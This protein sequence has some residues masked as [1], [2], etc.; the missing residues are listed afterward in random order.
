MTADDTTFFAGAPAQQVAALVAALERRRFPEGAVV[1]AEGDAPHEMY[2]IESGVVEIWTGG[3]RDGRLLARLGPGSTVGEMSLFTGQPVSATARVAAG[4]PVDALVVGQDDFDRL[5]TTFPR[6]Y[7]NLGAIMAER[8]AQT[9]RLRAE[10]ERIEQEL[11]TAQ[12]IQ[13]T[14]LPKEVPTPVG[15]EIVPYYQPAHE[16]GGDFYDFLQ[17]ADGRL[18]LVIGD[19]TGKGIPAALVM[20]ATHTMIRAAAQESAS[21]GQ[22]FARV[23]DL[24]HADIPPGTFVT[25]FYAV[26]E[27]ESGRLRF[28]NAGHEAP[29]RC[30]AGHATELWASGM[31]LGLMPGTQYEEYDAILAPGESL[32]FYSDG[33][34]E[35]H[36]SSHEMFGLARVKTLLEADADG[37]DADGAGAGT[38][39]G[40]TLIGSLLDALRR[41][42]GEGGEQ[43]D[44][45]TLVVLHRAS[46]P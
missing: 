15:W 40:T 45:V 18:G 30:L 14:F 39:S 5:A 17:L 27:P 9:N 43:E 28:A 33:L 42:T 34:V 4:S 46:Q 38:F 13:H 11:Q 36:S 1:L 2:I 41:F 22:I 16:L 24:L 29:F 23:N 8:L 31:P 20:T 6:L 10:P 35:A 21:P 3:S 12:A 7:R 37:A 26:I 25:C 32:L 19:V 44:D